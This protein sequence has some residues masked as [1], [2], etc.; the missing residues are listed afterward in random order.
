MIAD[1]KDGGLA[2]NILRGLMQHSRAREDRPDEWRD[3]CDYMPRAVSSA[4]EKFG[5]R[6]IEA[7]GTEG[8]PIAPNLQRS[9][10]SSRCS[11]V[12]SVEGRD[13]GLRDARHGRCQF[14]TRRSGLAR[15]DRTA[16]VGQDRTA[17]FDI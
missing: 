9:R 16:L 3:R 10:P 2:V 7:P 12:A 11:Q 15:P 14:V 1:G 17:Q 13:A 4:Q 8:E 5:K 6:N